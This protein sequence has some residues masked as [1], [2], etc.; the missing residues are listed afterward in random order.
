MGGGISKA[1]LG[2]LTVFLRYDTQALLQALSEEGAGFFL[3]PL[4][5]G[6]YPGC[7]CLNT[8]PKFIWLEFLF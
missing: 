6:I 8:L 4:L 3:S 7:S 1:S 2:C 5:E